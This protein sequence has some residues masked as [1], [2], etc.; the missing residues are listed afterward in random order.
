MLLR[1]VKAT[2]NSGGNTSWKTTQEDRSERFEVLEFWG[3]VDREI[4]EDQGVDIP[5]DLE[6]ADQLSVNIWIC[7][8]QV[9]RLVMN[10]FTPAILPYCSSF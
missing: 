6:D 5:K 8:G 1:L 10:P 4:I 2:V 9:L 7:N 3:F